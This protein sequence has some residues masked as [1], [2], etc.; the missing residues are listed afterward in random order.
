MEE[1]RKVS[2]WVTAQVRKKEK[3][4]FSIQ[5]LEYP[6][7]AFPRDKKYGWSYLGNEKSCRRSAG[8]K[9]TVSSKAFGFSK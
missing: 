2:S 1:F 8:G 5:I 6:I 4:L 7:P 3:N 9:T